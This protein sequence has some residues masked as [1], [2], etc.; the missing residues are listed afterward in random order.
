MFAGNDNS[1]S[2]SY[3]HFIAWAS[4]YPLFSIFPTE[5]AIHVSAPARDSAEIQAS[6][7]IIILVFDPVN[8]TVTV[9]VGMHYLQKLRSIQGPKAVWPE[10]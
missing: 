9:A 2:F 7:L 4:F 8:Q 10:S 6:E 5:D 1:F 3:I